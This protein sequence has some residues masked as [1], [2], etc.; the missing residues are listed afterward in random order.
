MKRRHSAEP[1]FADRW[2]AGQFLGDALAPFVADVR[3][4]DRVVLGLARGG[5]VV[6]AEVAARLGAILDAIVVRKIGSPFQPELAIGAV[7]PEGVRVFNRGV[8][9][10]LGLTEPE[11][12]DLADQVARTRDLLND[13]LRGGRP[14]ARLEGK[15]AILVDDGLATG[16]S[17]R[18]AVTYA[19]RT[20]S[21]VIVAVPT[22]APDVLATF[23][24]HGT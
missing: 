13:E 5:V 17:M 14:A 2:Q 20:A 10:D 9:A 15:L 4:A 24:T 7:G 19:R 1:R 22:A 8:V 16:A 23:E 21:A 11:V 6:A 12:S 3:P 18:A